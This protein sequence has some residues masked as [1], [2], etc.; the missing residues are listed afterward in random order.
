MAETVWGRAPSRPYART[1]LY[2]GNDL[3][4]EVSRL[5]ARRYKRACRRAG[6]ESLRL[7]LSGGSSAF[8]SAFSRAADPFRTAAAALVYGSAGC[9]ARLR[10]M[11]RSGSFSLERSGGAARGKHN[12]VRFNTA[13]AFLAAGV[14][15]FAASIYRVGLEVLLDGESIGYVASQSVVETSLAAVSQRAGDILGRSFT[16][17]PDIIYR[18]SIVSRNQMYD[19]AGV[20]AGLLGSIPD[21]DR[22]CVLSVDGQPVGAA[23]TPSDLQEVLRAL[24]AEYPSDGQTVFPQEVS[25][26]SQLAPISLLRTQDELLSTL[27]HPVREEIRVTVGEGDTLESLAA[28]CRVPVETLLSL[29]PLLDGGT[30]VSGQ[31]LLVQRAKPMLSVMYKE[32]VSYLQPVAYKTETVD[33][34]T[35][36]LGE[37]KVITEGVDGEALVMAVQTSL[38]GYAPETEVTSMLTV[39]APVNEVIAN[40]TKTRSA[41]NTFIRP[42]YGQISSKFGMRKLLGKYEMH[43]GVDF[44]GPI[45]DPIVAS[46]G[47]VIAYAG[48]KAGYG[49]CVIIDHQNGYKTLYGHCSKLLVKEGQKVGQGERIANIGNTGRTTGPHVHFEVQ[50][51]GVAKNPMNYIYQ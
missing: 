38:D 1:G 12:H 51:N 21:I 7:R 23:W 28:A 31:T 49:L 24:L 46:D 43:Y 47:G 44:R 36:W 33:D 6:R 14:L 41:T 17:S 34:P 5:T 29:N 2:T 4:W 27:T 25:I 48:T 9:A 45:G 50:V 11:G 37:T 15:I 26:Q 3:C 30:P 20:E 16:V 35:L 10:N 19:S 22:L 39:T 8:L 18:F 40:G 32:Q 13:L 42:Y